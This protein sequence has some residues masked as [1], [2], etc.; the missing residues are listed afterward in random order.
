MSSENYNIDDDLTHLCDNIPTHY[1]STD[2]HGQQLLLNNNNY[3][4]LSTQYNSTTSLG[5]PSNENNNNY[6]GLSTQYNSISSL[7]L[8]SNDNNN[9]YRGLSTQHNSAALLGLPSNDNSNLQAQQSLIT[10]NY[11]NNATS[12]GIVIH[13]DKW[14]INGI[15]NKVCEGR[16][17]V[18]HKMNILLEVNVMYVQKNV[19]TAKDAKGKKCGNYKRPLTIDDITD[20]MCSIFYNMLD[21]LRRVDKDRI[22]GG[23]KTYSEKQKTDV[24]VQLNILRKCYYKRG[25]NFAEQFLQT[26]IFKVANNQNDFNN[27]LKKER[28][29]YESDSSNGIIKDLFHHEIKDTLMDHCR[30]KCAE[31]MRRMR[32][33]YHELQDTKLNDRQDGWLFR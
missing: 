25:E 3:R 1:D 23:N 21:Y 19:P 7:G 17:L 27:M 10:D 15:E 33:T 12:N 20:G 28:K 8:P 9:N 6:R 13:R 5:L 4:G 26:R 11:Y 18:R 30:E 2:M 22:L 14:F 32:I 16:L 31:E 24:C 29:K